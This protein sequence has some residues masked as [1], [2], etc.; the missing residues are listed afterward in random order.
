MEPNDTKIR[1]LTWPILPDNPDRSGSDLVSGY[2]LACWLRTGRRLNGWLF[3]GLVCAGLVTGVVVG[4]GFLPARLTTSELPTSPSPD[5]SSSCPQ[6]LPVKVL[7]PKHDPRHRI[8]IQQPATIEPY[9]KVS[10]RSRVSGVVQSVT[11]DLG[12]LVR[13]GELLVVLAV[14]DLEQALEQKTGLIAQREKEWE[15]ARRELVVAEAGVETARVNVRVKEIEVAR[16]KDHR[17][18]R[19]TEWEAITLLYNQNAVVKSRV[20]AAWRDYQAAQRAVEAAEVE[21]DK[22]KVELAGKASS[23]EKVAAEVEL[24]R[25]LIDVARREREAAAIPLGYSRLYAPFDGVVIARA[26]DPGNFVFSGTSGASEPLITVARTDLVKVVAKVPDRVAPFI[27]PDTEATIE[28]T[29]LPGVQIRGPITR[30]SQAIDPVEHTMRVE[31]DIFNGTY[32]EYQAL[33][34]RA[35]LRTTVSPLI[36]D[37]H[38]APA[39]MVAGVFRSY[40][41]DGN[42]Q[43]GWARPLNVGPEHR[44]PKILPGTT[45]TLWL[46]LQKF[47]DATVL[48]ASAVFT[49]L[50][51]P[52]ILMVENGVTRIVP[53]VVQVNDGEIAKVAILTTHNG[54]QPRTR[55]L[56]GQ[57]LIVLNRQLE[58]GEGRR[59]QPIVEDW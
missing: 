43:E 35:A 46:D 10:L 54:G 27:S 56:T 21:L 50:G 25:F 5:E 1:E 13:S 53:V 12:E 15:V 22:A 52:S 31:V 58:V 57:E 8:T 14:P 44:Y 20:D 4:V 59:V 19:K 51:Q 33:L 36:P 49:H 38:L 26:V 45:A 55:E 9:Y 3:V 41:D 11:K 2:R 39:I 37:V 34:T 6:P 29:H 7:R 32:T 16:A 48:P 23:R 28:F 18:A 40:A 30:F 42:W 17:D 24:K 47:H